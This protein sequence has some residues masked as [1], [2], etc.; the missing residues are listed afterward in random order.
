MS[1]PLA[2]RLAGE[3]GR[4]LQVV[5]AFARLGADPHK[6]ARARAARAREREATTPAQQT[7]RR[8]WAR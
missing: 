6:R 7:R 8:G 2:D 4:Y 5:D 3:A 1:G